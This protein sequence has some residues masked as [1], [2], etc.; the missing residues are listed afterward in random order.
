MRRVFLLL[1]LAVLL[2]IIGWFVALY[3]EKAEFERRVAAIRAAGQ[4]TTPEELVPKPI[5]DDEN[6]AVLLREAHAL[7]EKIEEAPDSGDLLMYVDEDEWDDEDRALAEKY[8][9]D[10]APFRQLVE[11]AAAQPGFDARYPYADGFEALDETLFWLQAVGNHYRWQQ[12]LDREPHGCTERLIARVRLLLDLADLPPATTVLRWLVCGSMRDEAIG[13]IRIAQGRPGFDAAALRRKLEPRIARAEIPRGPPA[14]V[15]DSERVCHLICI[16]NWLAGSAID[17]ESLAPEWVRMTSPGNRRLLY[18]DA[19]L[20]LEA[21]AR[22][23]AASD[24]T[25]EE[26][27]RFELDGPDDLT[28]YPL[29]TTATTIF[30]RVFAKYTEQVAALRLARAALAVLEHRQANGRWPAGLP[31]G[32]PT[33]PYTGRPLIYEGTA[34]GVRLRAASPRREDDEDLAWEFV[35]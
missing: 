20:A 31:A 16:R 9:R 28:L 2:G 23:R 15:I 1:G 19:N 11:R 5:P 21:F 30:P 6:A 25:P 8:F 17:V 33:D 26:A 29:A 10:T 18:R 24:A 14:S 4:P 32:L 27:H 13:L 34:T 3:V 35:D 12:Q 7:L 22:V